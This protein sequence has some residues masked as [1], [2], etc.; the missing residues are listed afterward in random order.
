MFFLKIIYI[1]FLNIVTQY[2]KGWLNLKYS[3]YLRKLCS[4]MNNLHIKSKWN[5]KIN[6]KSGFLELKE[7]NGATFGDLDRLSI[8]YIFCRPISY[9]FTQVIPNRLVFVH[10]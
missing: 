7:S 9:I 10:T 2:G 4:F 5:D 8:S 6:K 1:F 3:G